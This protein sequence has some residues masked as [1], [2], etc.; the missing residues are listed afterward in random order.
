VERLPA[1]VGELLGL[2]VDVMV[3]SSS[4]A[5]RASKS[6]T[7]TIPIV[8]L[9]SADAVGEGFVASLARPGGNV[10]GM[11]LLVGP[12]IASKQLEFLREIDPAATR[13][14]VLINPRNASGITIP[15]GLRL[16]VDKEI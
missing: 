10:T 12:D 13:V 2:D 3:V 14:A 15:Q 8:M 16:R 11:T 1:L 9:A 7:K 4:A 5:T 6:A